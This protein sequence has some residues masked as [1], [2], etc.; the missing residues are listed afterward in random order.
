MNNWKI[1][2]GFAA[3]GAMASLLA[4]IIGGNPFGVILLRMALSTVLCAGLGLG[5]NLVVKKFLPELTSA[6]PMPQAES[7]EEVDI[8]IDE[9]IPLQK[10]AEEQQTLEPVEEQ[11]SAELAEMPEAADSLEPVEAAEMKFAEQQPLSAEDAAEEVESP[12]EDLLTLESADTE[13]ELPDQQPAPFGLPPADF[14]DLDTLPDMDHFS[15]A[16]EESPSAPKPS[17]MNAQ[18][19]KVVRD[20]DPENLARAVRTFMKKDQ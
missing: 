20:Q 13:E 4:G 16:A 8:V 7:G 10:S 12:E 15:P 11:Q 17:R 3:F 14:E 1:P 18:V 9:E 2:A 5:I 6:A 19:E